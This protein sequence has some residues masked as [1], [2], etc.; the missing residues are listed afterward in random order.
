[1]VEENNNNENDSEFISSS[2][3]LEI[4]RPKTYRGYPIQ[5][6]DWEHLKGEVKKHNR[7]NNIW[8]AICSGLFGASGPTTNTNTA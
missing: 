1:M 2:Q 5:K 6:E 4:V 7:R 3:D 8:K